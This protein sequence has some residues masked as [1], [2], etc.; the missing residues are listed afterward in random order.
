MAG[1]TAAMVKDLREATNVGMMECKR[2]LEEAG[3]DRE[4][5]IRI[6][7]ERGLAIAG[8]KATRAANDGLVAA[9]VLEGGRR[10]V[11]IEVNCETDFVARNAVFQEFVNQLLD[12]A[13]E[14][15]GD[16]SAAVADE[17]AAKVAEIGENIV[18]R[19]NV[20]YDLHGEGLI[21]A[22]V[23]L[24]GKIGVLVEIG[25][26]RPETA[27]KD[28]FRA[29]AKDVTLH[30]AASYPQYLKRDEVPEE[31]I[32]AEKAIYA[33]QVENK[34][35][36]I[37]EKIVNGKLGKFFGQICLLEQ[38]FVKDSDVT[39]SEWLA[40]RGKELDDELTIRRFVRYQLGQGDA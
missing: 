18:V 36:Q 16:L 5:A 37:V 22:Y 3:G 8:R 7:R 32:E 17:V 11:M 24:G 20:K 28:E 9:R 21:A 35:P 12:R 27:A 23:H 6:L 4:K 13:G 34:P 25:C 14:I 38:G 15:E 31:A 40:A 19:R 29:I 10:G 30:I 2:A 39:V 26:G 1:I 33:K